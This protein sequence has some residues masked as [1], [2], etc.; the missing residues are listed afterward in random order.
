MVGEPRDS[1]SSGGIF[2]LAAQAFPITAKQLMI[3]GVFA[4]AF[5]LPAFSTKTNGFAISRW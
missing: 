5:A 4:S 2:F 3:L 1:G